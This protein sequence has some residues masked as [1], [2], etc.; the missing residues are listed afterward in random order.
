MVRGLLLHASVNRPAPACAQ[1][2]MTRIT[3]SGAGTPAAADL[4]LCCSTALCGKV[5]DYWHHARHSLLTLHCP[6]VHVCALHRLQPDHLD[7]LATGS[8]LQSL[9]LCVYQTGLGGSSRVQLNP[10][11]ALTRLRSLDVAYRGEAAPAEQGCA[12]GDALRCMTR[13]T[14][15]WC[16]QAPLS[17]GACTP[18]LRY[19]AEVTGGLRCCAWLGRALHGCWHVWENF[20]HRISLLSY[21]RQ[22]TH[23]CCCGFSY[24]CGPPRARRKHVVA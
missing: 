10:L 5:T 12:W 16:M 8:Q 23:S 19:I 22:P 6:A 24:F 4:K 20:W 15:S 3:A 17:V 13:V 21:C 7:A 2:I 9:S 1:H 18:G 11:L 14:L